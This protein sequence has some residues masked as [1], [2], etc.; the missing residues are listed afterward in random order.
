VM[1]VADSGQGEGG[2]YM[3]MVSVELASDGSQVA[4]LC[5]SCNCLLAGLEELRTHMSDTHG[6][7]VLIMPDSL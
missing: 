1:T 7:Q 3:E 4:Y 5:P 2:E 6:A